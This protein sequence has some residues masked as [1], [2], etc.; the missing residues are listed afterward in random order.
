MLTVVTVCLNNP[1]ELYRTAQS[2]QLQTEQPDRYLV[3]DSS[4]ATHK[5]AMK[6][7]AEAAGA[8]YVWVPPEGVYAAMATSAGLVDKASW[9]WWVNSSDWLAGKRSIAAAREAIS[10]AEANSH[11]WIIGELMRLKRNGP[12]SVHRCGKTGDEFVRMLRT[13]R[14]GFPHPSTIFRHEALSTIRPYNDGFSIASDYGTALRFGKSFGPPLL[15][16]ASLAVHDPTGLTSRYPA[17]NLW[18]RSRARIASGSPLDAVSELWRFPRSALRGALTKLI[19]EK[20]VKR[21]S[22]R[23]DHFPLRGN[24]PFDSASETGRSL[25][26]TA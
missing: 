24:E 9:V 10:E 3:V 20:P 7:I 17:K 8:E 12:P 4:D 15:V 14:T 5:P 23:R 26:F 25:N 18:E 2:V 19:G 1:T 22:T 21:D 11:N 13:G 6:E 16:P